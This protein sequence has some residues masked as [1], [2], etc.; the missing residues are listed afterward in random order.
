MSVNDKKIPDSADACLE[1]LR[2]GDKL[3]Q[4]L[5]I[6]LLE[7]RKGYGKAVMPM[8]SRHLNA[9]GILHGGAIFTLAD[10]ALALVANSDGVLGLTLG[11]NISFFKA[12]KHAPF[13]AIAR[14]T[15]ASSK[16]AHYEVTVTDA[17]GEA[18]A[19]L[20]GMAYKKC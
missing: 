3:A 18:I 9:A 10:V 14:E 20:N 4:N 16:V 2:S 13:T 5:G 17:A 12:G 1:L 7:C 19:K 11:A 6:E 15:S 8:D